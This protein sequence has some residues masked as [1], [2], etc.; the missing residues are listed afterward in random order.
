MAAELERSRKQRAE[1]EAQ[2]ALAQAQAQQLEL[3]QDQAKQRH[4]AELQVL[5][6]RMLL[7]AAFHA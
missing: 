2:L 1:V 5:L 3:L 6:A 4:A 7:P